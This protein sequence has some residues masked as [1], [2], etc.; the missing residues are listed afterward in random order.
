MTAAI[1]D[2]EP[3]AAELLEANLARGRRPT[4]SPL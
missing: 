3:D 4:P 2:H 1:V